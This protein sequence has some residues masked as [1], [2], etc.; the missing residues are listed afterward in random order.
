MR[1]R[2]PP[3]ATPGRG[4]VVVDADVDGAV[5]EVVGVG[6]GE[7]EALVPDGVELLGPGTRPPPLV[8]ELHLH[9]RRRGPLPVL[10]HE[11]VRRHH[12][13]HQLL[14]RLRHPNRFSSQRFT[15]KL[16]QDFKQRMVA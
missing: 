11:V 14:R 16:A 5:G 2:P 12:L 7:D 4:A 10:G 15:K 6:D 9:V 13:H 3:P 8:L 1:R